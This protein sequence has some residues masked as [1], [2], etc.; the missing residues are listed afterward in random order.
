MDATNKPNRLQQLRSQA[1]TTSLVFAILFAIGFVLIDLLQLGVKPTQTDNIQM[2]ITGIYP[3]G[4]FVCLKWRTI[5][6]LICLLGFIAYMIT[7]VL[8]T[9]FA[10]AFQ[11]VY[12][13][14]FLVQMVPVYL[15]LRLWNID[16]H[17]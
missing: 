4:L 1:R 14:I 6:L 3:I 17:G 11:L 10:P 15:N 16:R 8:W 12:G 2:W 7:V 9:G 13:V 5:G